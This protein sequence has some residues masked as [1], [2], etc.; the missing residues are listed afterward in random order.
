MSAPKPESI[1]DDE[2]R[3]LTR[4]A[5]AAWYRSS[6][7]Q[8]SIIDQPAN[9]SGVEEH[10]GRRYVVLRNI[11]GVM[12]VYRQRNDGKLKHLR[13]APRGIAQECR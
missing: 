4:R 13:R 1:T 11:R 7:K 10:D 5:I 8:S 12:A 6:S 2:E 3:D 9:Y